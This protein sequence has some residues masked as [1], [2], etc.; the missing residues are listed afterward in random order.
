MKRMLLFVGIFFAIIFGW[1]GAKKVLMW[2]FMSHY[3]PPAVTISAVTAKSEMWSPYLEAVGTLTAVNGVDLSSEASGIIKTIRFNSGQYVHQGETV[4]QLETS[5]EEALLK[6]RQAQLKLAQMNYERDKKLYE[7]NVS[8]QSALD[9]R[10]AQLQAAESGVESVKAQIRQKNIVAPFSG[11]LGI[12]QVNLGQFL[13]AGTTVVTLQS[14]NPLYVLFNLPEQF[15]PQ[16]FLNQMVDVTV[17]FGQ[18]KTIRGKITAINSKVDQVTRNVQIQ[19]TINNEKAQLYPGMF[20]SIKVWSRAKENTIII[21]QTAVSY[22]LSGDYVFLIKNESKNKKQ[23]DLRVYRQY[24][25]VGDH[26]G[27]QVSI[28][29]G[30]KAGDRIVTS[31]QLKLQNATRITIDNKVEL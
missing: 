30:L 11:R 26:R 28:L 15:L 27:A 19:A 29:E 22:S 12:R 16:L 1:Y 21:P 31:G 10:F 25:K 6:D 17:N 3:Q 2:W 5:V 9:T 14:L 4:L 13:S 20:A 18:G 8:S 24:I 7:K 23:E